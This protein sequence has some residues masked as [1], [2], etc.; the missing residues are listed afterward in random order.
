MVP[1]VIIIITL[2]HL[3]SVFSASHILMCRIHLGS[4][5]EVPR[6]P[7]GDAEVEFTMPQTT[8]SRC[9]VRSLAVASDKPSEK[10]IRYTAHYEY[11]VEIENKVV[12]QM[13]DG[14][15]GNPDQCHQQWSG[16]VIV[17]LQKQ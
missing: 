10:R 17:P 5:R 13:L 14:D 16:N 7:Q 6:T 4:H 2:F 1:I 9:T 3:S 12:L 15:D 8:A 11:F